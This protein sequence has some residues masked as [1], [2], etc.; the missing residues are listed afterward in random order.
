MENVNKEGLLGN[1]KEYSFGYEQ[2]IKYAFNKKT[3]KVYFN[4]FKEPISL[5]LLKAIL[6]DIKEKDIA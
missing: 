4:Q 3:R 2:K 5:T 1:L 6:K